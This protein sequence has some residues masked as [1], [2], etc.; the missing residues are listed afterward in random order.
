VLFLDLDRFKLIN[1]TLGHDIGDG[2]LQCVAGR[3][4]A[5]TRATDTVSRYG[6]DE[7][8]LF[9][10][11][12][13]T[14]AD[15]ARVA[16]HVLRTLAEPMRVADH[17]LC[18]RASV[19]VS[20]YP[21][22]GKDMTT[23]LRHADAAMYAAKESGGDQHRFY[24]EG[25]N[26]RAAER[27]SLEYDLR[28]ALER[29][30]LSVAYQPQVSLSTGEVVGIE[31]LA[32]WRHPTAGPISPDRFI[33]V[34][35]DTGLIV[36]LDQWVMR[37]ACRQLTA[38]KRRGVLTAGMAVNVSPIELHQAR[39]HDGVARILEEEQISPADVEL[40]VTESAMV[41]GADALR[42]QLEALQRL[43]VR[44]AID[45]FGTGYSSLSYLRQFPLHRLKI[46]RS[47]VTDL[48]HNKD[49][50]AI[51]LAIVQMGHSL[52]LSVIAEGVETE[53]QA[54][55]LRSIECDDAQG[56]LFGKPVSAD[57]FERWLE[58]Q[59][60]PGA[61]DDER[62]LLHVSRSGNRYGV[63]RPVAAASDERE[64]SAASRT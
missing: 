30:E 54:A 43:G 35:E 39:F 38:W 9:L 27:L 42:P 12:I 62:A 34:A 37:S 11:A 41:G 63:E 26:A 48:P 25:M 14:P 18:I 40:E 36:P 19:G 60:L 31:A 46:D 59:R 22:H 33:P 17:D 21:D 58:H 2:V 23:L 13:D 10:T 51:A 16:E 3:L 45:D 6:G 44:L 4:R 1:D 47:F 56:Y 8:V 64:E 50:A 28:L 55:Y 15:A 32:R 49:A 61:F 7:F 20:I 53:D 52:G 29:D 24:V 57:E 5:M